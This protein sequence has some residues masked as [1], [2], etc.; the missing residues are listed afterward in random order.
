MLQLIINIIISYCIYKMT[1]KGWLGLLDILHNKKAKLSNEIDD[2]CQVVWILTKVDDFVPSHSSQC[3]RELER[4][5]ERE[6][7]N[8]MPSIFYGLIPSVHDNPL[9]QQMYLALAIKISIYLR[10]NLSF[11]CRY[12]R[13]PHVLNRYE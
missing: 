12:L 7:W 4:E 8:G 6:N 10:S 13:Y 3:K 11:T 5:R 9:N 1:K 2:T